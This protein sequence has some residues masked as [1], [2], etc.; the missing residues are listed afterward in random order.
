MTRQH[1]QIVL[2]INEDS[3]APVPS[4]THKSDSCIALCFDLKPKVSWLIPKVRTQQTE[5]AVQIR[6]VVRQKLVVGTP[7]APYVL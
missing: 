7:C 1:L 4:Q 3:G 2:S 6:A 5:D